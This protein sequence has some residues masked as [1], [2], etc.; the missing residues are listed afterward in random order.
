MDNLCKINL[1]S[2]SYTFFLILIMILP[3]TSILSISKL[4][5]Q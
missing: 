3:H 2:I 1:I 4:Q 5:T